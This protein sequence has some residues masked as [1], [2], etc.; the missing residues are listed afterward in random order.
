MYLCYLMDPKLSATTALVPR[1]LDEDMRTFQPRISAA[2]DMLPVGAATTD[3]PASVRSITISAP[4]EHLLSHARQ[5]QGLSGTNSDAIHAG[6][7]NSS[8]RDHIRLAMVTTNPT[9]IITGVEQ[10]GM[11]R[12]PTGHI[13][14]RP[15]PLNRNRNAASPYLPPGESTNGMDTV[16][17]LG[18]RVLG[19][20]QNTTTIHVTSPS[21]SDIASGP[22]VVNNGTDRGNIM[23]TS[24]EEAPIQTTSSM[25]V[26]SSSSTA[27]VSTVAPSTADNREETDRTEGQSRIE[28]I[29]ETY[30]VSPGGVATTELAF[31]T[32]PSVQHIRINDGYPGEEADTLLAHAVDLQVSETERTRQSVHS[33]TFN[34]ALTAEFFKNPTFAFVSAEDPQ[35]WIWW[36]SHHENNLQRCRQEGPHEEVMMWWRTRID[37]NS[38]ESKARRRREKQRRHMGADLGKQIGIRDRL[39]ALLSLRSSTPHHES[40]EITMRVRG[41][42]YAWRE[43]TPEAGSPPQPA[44]E[45]EQRLEATAARGNGIP[46]SD[47]SPQPWTNTDN[48]RLFTLVRDDSLVMGQRV[49]GGP[50]AEIWI[51][52]DSVEPQTS[53]P[54]HF[55]SIPTYQSTVAPVITAVMDSSGGDT[56]V[57]NTRAYTGEA[58]EV[59]DPSLATRSAASSVISYNGTT[60]NTF[61]TE[62]SAFTGGPVRS[63]I[64]STFIHPAASDHPS[65]AVPSLGR[66]SVSSS[67]MSTSNGSSDSRFTSSF[68]PKLRQRRC[69]IRVLRGLNTEVETFALS[70]GPRL[71]ELFDLY[72]DQSLPGPSKSSFVCA[73]TT[74]GIMFLATFLA[75][76]LIPR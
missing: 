1:T 31:G 61:M 10:D 71:P 44:Q 54:D 56:V 70:T 6:N 75:I 45:R 69:M 55:H 72:T 67:T 12:V 52:G 57:S 29:T 24:N 62:V 3:S 33:N 28:D 73:L 41:L 23:S 63:T 40:M 74:F 13:R 20:R 47:I 8:G 11:E 48:M 9:D 43:E 21:E 38:R 7:D 51:H 26:D 58:P 17:M 59:N 39:R 22:M 60:A 4:Q 16:I 32:L 50:V 35:T 49:K 14:G 30:T 46:L 37:F 53:A 65:S 2:E 15:P 34:N 64:A 36:S 42:Y 66:R 18:R 76:A 25:E 27:H 68:P 5:L 19:G